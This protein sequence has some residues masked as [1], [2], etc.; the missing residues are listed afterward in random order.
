MVRKRTLL[1]KEK[2]G[3][4]V[5][6]F[7]TAHSSRGKTLSR[8]VALLL[9]TVLC[10]VSPRP[11]QSAETGDVKA[12]FPFP[13]GARWQYNQKDLSGSG[14][15]ET[16][17]LFFRGTRK[18]EQVESE[19]LIIDEVIPRGTSPTGYFLKEGFLMKVLGLAYDQKEKE[20]IVW[21]S[22]Q[23]RRNLGLAPGNIEKFLPETLTVGTKWQSR[24]PVLN[25]VIDGEY[26]IVSQ[27]E[28][29]VP[30]GKYPSCF[31]I[32][33]VMK[34]IPM[35][36]DGKEI[37]EAT[38]SFSSSDWYAAGV[39]LVKSKVQQEGKETGEI[40]LLKYEEGKKNGATPAH[41]P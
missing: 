25:A 3:K 13:E 38:T 4:K 22:E 28:I 2:V 34:V 36:P 1:R 30:A 27:E 33:S 31:R 19:L 37:T 17:E 35:G 18:V 14:V 8:E 32:D 29:E 7:L 40:L 39:G 20:K 6:R 26:H 24:T 21:Q 41:T 11:S 16:Y 10:F 15:E 23:M 12:L 5:S 9:F